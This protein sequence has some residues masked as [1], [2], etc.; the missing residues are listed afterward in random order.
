MKL[1]ILLTVI[2]L[3]CTE[4]LETKQR[5]Q[6]CESFCDN[7]NMESI[8]DNRRDDCICEEE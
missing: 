4:S 1:L 3:S 7:L 8:Y 6:E 5:K 2:L